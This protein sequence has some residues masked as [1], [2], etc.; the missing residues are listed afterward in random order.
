MQFCE[1]KIENR[2]YDIR[3]YFGNFYILTYEA[4]FEIQK[5]MLEKDYIRNTLLINNDISNLIL[6]NHLYI[7]DFFIK[8]GKGYAKFS[9][10]LFIINN[11]QLIPFKMKGITHHIYTN[12]DNNKLYFTENYDIVCFD[13]LNDC[14]KSIVFKTENFTKPRNRIVSHVQNN[15]IIYK[16]DNIVNVENFETK[17]IKT[18]NFRNSI[19]YHVFNE[20]ITTYAFDFKKIAV[21]SDN[22]LRISTFKKINKILV[23]EFT[24][25]IIHVMFIKYFIILLFSKHVKICYLNPMK[26]IFTHRF[27]HCVENPITILNKKNKLY[28]V[29]SEKIVGYN[30]I[31]IEK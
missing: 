2:L 12:S 27:E 20:S 16:Y 28:I 15:I 19:F 8:E 4:L 7:E 14:K 18:F 23:N 5:S 30:F 10:T 31:N 6:R 9:K 17:Q 25:S 13:L 29:N 21:C 11:F 3:G 24:E 1:N 22:I 26:L